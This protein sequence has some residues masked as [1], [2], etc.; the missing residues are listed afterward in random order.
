MSIVCCGAVL[1]GKW[2]NYR[3]NIIKSDYKA[4]VMSL[5]SWTSPNLTPL[6]FSEG[7]EAHSKHYHLLAAD[8]RDVSELESK[9][10]KVGV[11]KR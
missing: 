4:D 2:L 1:A 11:D 8:L 10:N 7:N 3:H 6:L 9:L 5:S